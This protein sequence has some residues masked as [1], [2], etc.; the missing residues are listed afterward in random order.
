MI[1]GVPALERVDLLVDRAL[2]PGFVGGL[3]VQQEEVAVGERREHG[4]AL[5]G[6]VVVEPGGRAGDVDAPRCPVSTPSPRTRSTADDSRPV[7]AV[8]VGERRE[9]RARRPGPTARSASRPSRP[10]RRP[11]ATTG[12]DASISAMS[13][14]A[15][16]PVGSTAGCP[17]RSCGGTH[18]AS[19]QSPR[20]DAQVAVLDAG[21]EAHAV[22]PV[23]ERGVERG[24]DRVALLAREVAGGEVDH[25]AVGVDGDEVAAVRDLVGRELDA[26]RRGLDRRAA[27]VVLGRVV[28]EDREVADVAARAAARR[29]SPSARP[30]SPRA[31]S[32]REVRH[33][34]GFERRAA[35]ELV[36]RLVGA[37]VG[38]EHDVLHVAQW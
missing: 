32:A 19:A 13:F 14:A 25:R 18:S 37:T 35:A 29:G 17:V 7:D 21:V 2:V 8:R 11:R 6:V 31:A 12:F 1:V 26:H 15:A 3:D 27:G 24:D 33:A 28:A 20:H 30:T 34:R 9:L 23:A 5:R 4:V 10:R 16:G 36:E 22:A 38:N